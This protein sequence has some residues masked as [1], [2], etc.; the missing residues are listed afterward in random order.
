MK[1][2]LF[3]LAVVLMALGAK[4][5]VNQVAVLS[6]EGKLSFFYGS[7]ALAD[8]YE[9]AVDG[10]VITLSSG[11]FH[12]VGIKKAITLRGAGIALE[13]D[14]TISPTYINGELEVE[15]SEKSLDHQLNFDGLTFMTHVRLYE[16]KDVIFQKCEFM[17]AVNSSNFPDE[18]DNQK[19]VQYSFVHCFQSDVESPLSIRYGQ[20]SIVNSVL[21]ALSTEGNKYSNFNITNSIVMSSRYSSSLENCNFTNSV[22]LKEWEDGYGNISDNCTGTNCIVAGKNMGFKFGKNIVFIDNV[23]ELF[24]EGTFYELTEKAAEV[25]GTDGTQVGIYGGNFP[26][27]AAADGPKVKKF[28]VAPKTTADGKLSV[29]IE[30]AE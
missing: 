20:V 22:I 4:A 15:L 27:E 14:K 26:F 12:A 28:N 19:N 13:S 16:V 29:D 10:D 5:Q 30:I 6:N 2:I 25:L 18:A 1:K 8:A 23:E 9:K 24:K 3:L 11:S 17:G 7:G 21:K